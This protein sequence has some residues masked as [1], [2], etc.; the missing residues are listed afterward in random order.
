[1]A[2]SKH[3]VAKPNRVGSSNQRR[4]HPIEVTKSGTPR[5][6][7]HAGKV[8]QTAKQTIF[9]VDDETALS[10]HHRLAFKNVAKTTAQTAQDLESRARRSTGAILG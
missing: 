9:C 6:Y 1:M 4:A 7:R 2:F 8:D 5:M 10:S 3:R